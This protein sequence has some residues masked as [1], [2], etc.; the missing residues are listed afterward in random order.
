[1]LNPF[2]LYFSSAIVLFYFK[3]FL[4]ISRQEIYIITHKQTNTQTDFNQ[5]IIGK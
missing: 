2:V 5:L 4:Y 1:M 3:H